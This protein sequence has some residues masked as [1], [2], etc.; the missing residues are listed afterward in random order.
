MILL[1]PLMLTSLT[2]RAVGK[3]L[4]ARGYKFAAAWDDWPAALAAGMSVVFICTAVTHFVEPQRSGLIATVPGFIS[5]PGLA[6]TATGVIE[7]VL[8]AGLLVPRT[9]RLSALV[10]IVLLIALFPANVVAASGVEHAAAP[11]TALLPRTILQLIFIVCV[12]TPLFSRGFSVR[13][14]PSQVGASEA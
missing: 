14:G 12:A 11:S 6:V 13:S 4:S 5:E 7:F 1:L 3:R 9:R 2:V 8:A 10:A